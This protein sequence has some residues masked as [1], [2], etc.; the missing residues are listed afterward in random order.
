MTERTSR[1]APAFPGSVG[2]ARVHVVGAAGSGKTYLATAVSTALGLGRHELDLLTSR[3]T[4]NGRGPAPATWQQRRTA[5]AALAQQPAWVTEGIYLGWTEPLLERA[6]LVVWLD[7]PWWRATWRILSRHA[8][9][10]WHRDNEW[11]GLRLL[12]RFL[13]STRRY[14]RGPGGVVTSDHDD[15]LTDRR[16]T[17]TAL[18][19]YTAKVRRCRSSRDV[20]AVL[21]ELGARRLTSTRPHGRDYTAP[22]PSRSPS[23]PTGGSP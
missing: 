11:K 16:M 5:A 22:A 2:T 18:A 19:P 1:Q 14:Y 13:W 10:S 3:P 4:L 17:R 6:D 21:A 23:P 9:R 15:A 20:A 7:V 12:L 8:R